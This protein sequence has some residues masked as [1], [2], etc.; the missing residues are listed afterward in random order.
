MLTL[1]IKKQ[2]LITNKIK[3]RF[4][5]M[6]LSSNV[7]YWIEMAEYDFETAKAML[8]SK[9]Y[10]YVGFMCHQTI[11]KILKAYHVFIKNEAA[12]YTHNLMKLAGNSDLYAEF[13]EEQK[14]L[15]DLLEPLN[16]EARYPTNK[17]KLSKAL[18]EKRCNELLRNTEDLFQ[19][20]KKK[21]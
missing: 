7:N 18:T 21:F 17:E 5:K 6:A 4:V 8:K 9:R 11:E 19:W 1:C 20:I 16:I 3:D 2:T 12:Q 15:L 10:L 14:N 13:S